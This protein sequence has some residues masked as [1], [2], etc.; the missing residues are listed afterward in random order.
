[1]A[2]SFYLIHGYILWAVWT[3]FGIIQL[4]T[5]RY[6]KEY[7]KHAMWVHRVSGTVVLTTTAIYGGY[8]YWKLRYI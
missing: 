3:L 4:L 6:L 2:L 8:G 7:W 5:N 1:M